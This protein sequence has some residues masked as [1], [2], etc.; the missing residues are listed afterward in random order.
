M[1]VRQLERIFI[2]MA[3]HGQQNGHQSILN[4]YLDFS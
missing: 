1:K 4:K 3:S 2:T